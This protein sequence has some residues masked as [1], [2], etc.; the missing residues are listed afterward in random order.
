[1]GVQHLCWEGCSRTS[2]HTGQWLAT[3]FCSLCPQFSV[4]RYTEAHQSISALC[5][6]VEIPVLTVFQICE[7][8]VP[9]KYK[10]LYSKA[11]ELFCSTKCSIYFWIRKTKHKAGSAALIF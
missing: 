4:H 11:E 5:G 7:L 10:L 6:R 9:G 1:M 3:G 2:R 8:K